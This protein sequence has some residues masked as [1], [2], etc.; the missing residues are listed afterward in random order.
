MSA[1]TLI[2]LRRIATICGLLGVFL[3]ILGGFFTGSTYLVSFLGVLLVLVAWGDGIWL[4]AR[5]GR[6]SWLVV[7]A[8]FA[9]MAIVTLAM[10][11]VQIQSSDLRLAAIM[12][13]TFV[14]IGI[15]GIL[16]GAVS[17]DDAFVRATAATLGGAALILLIVGGTAI[18]DTVGANPAL[19]ATIRTLG[20]GYHL[21]L[22]TGILAFAAWIVG[23]ISAVRTQAWG[24]FTTA[25]ILP[26]IGSFMFGLFGPSAQDVIQARENAKSRREAGIRI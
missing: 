1:A 2:L 20:I 26:G 9:L 15:A 4:A 5:A 21:Y 3:L 10:S 12:I 7:H 23:L 6:M 24:W 11:F 8:Y 14:P 19:P 22:V 13:V 17:S 18:S 25:L 16:S